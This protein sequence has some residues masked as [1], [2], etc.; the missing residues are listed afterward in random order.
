MCLRREQR[1]Y[2]RVVECRGP[3]TSGI[4]Q[5]VWPEPFVWLEHCHELFRRVSGA[6]A[7]EH[8]SPPLSDVVV[9]VDSCSLR[10]SMGGVLVLLRPAEGLACEFLDILCG[11]KIYTLCEAGAGAGIGADAAAA[12]CCWC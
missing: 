8:S 5:N 2:C 4:A 1:R 10:P 11:Q 3:V 9:S 12:G 6:T 7:L